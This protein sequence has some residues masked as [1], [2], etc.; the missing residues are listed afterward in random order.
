MATNDRK[1]I[2]SG[3][4]NLKTDD[5]SAKS[6]TTKAVGSNLTTPIPQTHV[7]IS[8]NVQPSQ[9]SV[10]QTQQPLNTSNLGPYNNPQPIYGN[11][12]W[13]V[14]PMSNTPWQNNGASVQQNKPMTMDEKVDV[15]KK[16][17]LEVLGREA[18]T[19]DINY[20]K[21]GIVDEDTMRRKLTQ[22]NE[23]NDLVQKG[24][25]FQ[26]IK[27]LYDSTLAK[28]KMYEAKIRD[29]IDEF[30]KLQEML[31][32]KNRYIQG[33][34]I[35]PTTTV[36]QDTTQAEVPTVMTSQAT[37]DTSN[38]PSSIK[39]ESLIQGIIDFIKSLFN[40]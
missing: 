21:Y 16:M 6:A 7:N 22:T 19:K 3:Q 1:K 27:E 25:E 36:L 13:G 23:H 24:R 30:K 14:S 28:N 10:P 2:A 15:I 38:H 34:R 9:S 20:H 5:N 29:H 4:I 12:D 18:E 35:T 8:G 32:E 37:I 33:L 31:D 26:K 11:P 40:F 17:Y 39:N